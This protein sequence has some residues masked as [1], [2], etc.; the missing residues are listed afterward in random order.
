MD[1]WILCHHENT[2]PHVRNYELND[3][4]VERLVWTRQYKNSANR[5]MKLDGY[6]VEEEVKIQ[7]NE[8]LF[9]IIT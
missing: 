5:R 9:G 8:R 4:D 7:R 2:V 1:D 3:N 6:H